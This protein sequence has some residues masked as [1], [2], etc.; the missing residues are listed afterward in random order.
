MS[1]SE[2][3]LCHEEWSKCAGG[4]GNNTSESICCFVRVLIR[5]Q[6]RGCAASK[7]FRLHV[8]QT[9]KTL[10][11]PSGLQS[12]A[13]LNA[14]SRKCFFTTQCWLQDETEANRESLTK[15]RVCTNVLYFC[16]LMIFQVVLCCMS[17][18]VCILDTYSVL[19][20]HLNIK[21]KS[22]AVVECQCGIM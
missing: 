8:L 14:D 5:M 20:G 3:L 17:S 2:S 12:V 9:K 1:E 13:E 21:R 19:W 11:Q 6:I 15:V 10:F 7:M 18:L 16:Y 4:T 22:P